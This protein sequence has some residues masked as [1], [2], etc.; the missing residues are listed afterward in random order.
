MLA[1]ISFS[2]EK[3]ERINLNK[4]PS[5]AT[6]N[7]QNSNLTISSIWVNSVPVL[8]IRTGRIIE[9]M[10]S[11]RIRM[12][13]LPVKSLLRELDQFCLASCTSTF[14]SENDN[15]KTLTN[16]WIFY[17]RIFLF[18][19]CISLTRKSFLDIRSLRN[20]FTKSLKLEN[21]IYLNSNKSTRND[22]LITI[23]V[24]HFK[25]L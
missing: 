22:Y 20:H 3:N 1:I 11:Q 25:K 21:R 6:S 8:L 18:I 14:H 24:N 2:E 10:M 4:K 13:A 19:S 12:R 7:I 9:G 23:S 16:S 5:I 15:W 17:Y